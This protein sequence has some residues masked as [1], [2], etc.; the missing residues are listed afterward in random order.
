MQSIA[1]EVKLE[2]LDIPN[3]CDTSGLENWV[4]ARGR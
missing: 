1:R 2:K 4:E 3:S